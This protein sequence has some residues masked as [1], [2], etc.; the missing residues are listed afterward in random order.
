MQST[1]RDNKYVKEKSRVNINIQRMQKLLREH[2][3]RLEA[4]I[5]A[6]CGYINY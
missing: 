1:V 6:E 4:I 2:E 3:N 5:K